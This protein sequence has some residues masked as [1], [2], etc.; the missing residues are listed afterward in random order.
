M[1]DST[2]E[3]LMAQIEERRK[4]LMENLGDGSAKDFGDY[5][6]TVGTIRGFLTVQNMIKD[7]A[8]R[9]EH[10]EDE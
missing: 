4:V 3:Y 9:M 10:D 2:L 7:L 5:Q 6:M 8:K 1:I